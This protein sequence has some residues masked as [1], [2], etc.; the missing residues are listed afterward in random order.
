LRVGSKA[1]LFAMAV[2]MAGSL[3]ACGG[4]EGRLAKHMERAKEQLQRADRIKARLELKNVLQIDPKNA[5]A[6]FLSG[7]VAEQ[8]SDWANAYGF[9]QRAVE[10]RAGYTEAQIKLGRVFFMFGEPEKAAAMARAVLVQR[11]ND[12]EARTLGAAVKAAT[13]DTQAAIR[14]A[15]AVLG[16]HPGREDTI[17][18]LAGVY[19][20][21]DDNAGAEN[22]LLTGIEANARS[23]SMRLDLASLFLQTNQFARAEEPL[24]E[25][26][27]L[28]PGKLEHRVRLA[29]Y[30]ANAGALDKA[31][32]L[33]REVVQA[34]PDDEQRW[35]ILAEFLSRKRKPELAE[36]ELQSY[37]KEHGKSLKV[38]LALASLYQEMGRA[39][40]AETAH[41]DAVESSVSGPDRIKA[42]NELARFLMARGKAPEALALVSEIL[43]DNVRDEAALLTRGKLALEKRDAPSAIADFR[44]LVKGQPNAVEYLSLLARAHMLNGEPELA[45]ETLADAVAVN[46]TDAQVRLLWIEF[47]AQSREYDVALKEADEALKIAPLDLALLQIKA[48]LQAIKKDVKAAE[49]TM[50]QLKNIAVDQALGHHRLGSFYLASRK[51]E[52]AIAE[53]DAALK[54]SPDAFDSLAGIIQAYL[55][56][57]KPEAAL[58][59][60]AQQEKQ[61]SSDAQ[62]DY[63]RGEVY[64]SQEKH[65]AEAERYF[66]AA[67]RR[68]PAW[69]VPYLSL[70]NLLVKRRDFAAAEQMLREG[71]KSLPGDPLLMFS[72][73]S[74]F[75]T[76]GDFDRAQ[77]QYEAILKADPNLDIAANNLAALLTDRRGDK[78]SLDRARELAARFE[79]SYNPIFLD[80]LGWAFVKSGQVARGLPMLERASGLAPEI[81]VFQYHVGY[82]KYKKGELAEAK[83]HLRKALAGKADYPGAAEVKT[84]LGAL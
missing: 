19:R 25:V 49:Q 77:A 50:L 31:E 63:L 28:E 14:E 52:A 56:L 8:E 46:P 53:F 27:E 73:A 62:I 9:Y 45:R 2:I 4:R 18:L 17:S 26:A 76:A 29:A 59:R 44:A 33:L 38:R 11:P 34:A 3:G 55:G 43:K 72:L 54:K 81:S 64:A 6:F 51:F 5:E 58:A 13:G 75:E 24:R 12:P 36:L 23:V 40:A 60:L 79:N 1:V 65:A 16:S 83:V 35:L 20:K 37:L 21:L 84:L 42:R 48:A 61:K 30:Y 22:T 15:Q 82:G 67:I 41:R 47:L 39:D 7:Q 74:V 71:I 66:R 32:Q 69:Q 57:E 70:K 68:N 80:T 78:A 10:L